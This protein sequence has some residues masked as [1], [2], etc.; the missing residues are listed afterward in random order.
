MAAKWALGYVPVELTSFVGR[1][2]ELAETKRLLKEFRAV[3]LSGPGGVGKTRLALQV[4]ADVRRVFRD[5]VW[6]VE[7]AELRDPGLLAHVLADRLGLSDESGRSVADTVVGYLKQR[8]A[9][10]VL[11]NCEHIVDACAVF[12][13]KLLVNCPHLHVLATSRQSLGFSGEAVVRVP[14]LPVPD[15]DSGLS[16]EQ[17]AHYE[18]I[19]LFVDRAAA[20]QH[21]FAINAR[22]AAALIGICRH[23]DGIPLAIELAARRLRVLSVEEVEQ[24]LS[25]LT[26]RIGGQCHTAPARHQTLRALFDSSFELCSRQE[27]RIWARASVFSGGFD[28]E[29][30][31]YVCAGEGVESDEILG[32]VDGLVDKSIFTRD[33]QAAGVRYRMLEPIR[34][35]GEERL[36]EADDRD[37]AR[38]RHREWYADLAARFEADC[39]GIDQVAWVHR[40]RQE[41][42][43]LRRALEFCVT[44]PGQATAGMRIMHMIE[45]HWSIR[46]LLPEARHWLDQLLA[47]DTQPRWERASALRQNGMW[48]LLCG[49]PDVATPLLDEADELARRLEIDTVRAYIEQARGIAALCRADLE[50]ATALLDKSLSGFRDA[51]AFRGEVLTL[52]MLGY[53]L[54]LGGI[55]RGWD[56]L[57]ECITATTRRSEVYWR[58]WSWWALAHVELFRGGLVRADAAAHNALRLQRRLDNSMGTA[59]SLD[60]LAWITERYGRHIRAATLFGAADAVYDTVGASPAFYALVHAAHQEHVMLARAALGDAAFD[61]AYDKGRALRRELAIDYAL[62]ET[63][64]TQADTAH[65]AVG[66]LLTPREIEIAELAARGLTNREIATE[67]VVSQ[68]TAEAH[69]QHILVKL[70]FH[71]RVQIAGWIAGEEQTAP[72]SEHGADSG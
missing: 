72:V 70:G 9:L 23:L 18:A 17:L 25:Q 39:V 44:E 42:A 45:D 31:E 56:L 3:T 16:V 10:I 59:L 57:D 32:L 19:R 46:G 48:A 41:H 28:L 53:S 27:R 35:Y 64:P 36:L 33:E 54:A 38:L 50:Q 5:G 22:N 40:L 12:V 62:D 15:L 1:R 14:G 37:R 7:L 47:V 49:E 51:G 69:M 66:D 26:G 58:S 20:V 34:E 68:R 63:E 11:D 24:R 61:E 8:T 67:L 29:A 60:T 4:A 52:F 65:N 6:V 55:E 21:G 13:E 2:R 43:N 71:N 30:V